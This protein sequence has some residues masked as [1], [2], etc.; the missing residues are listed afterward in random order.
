[1]NQDKVQ[2]E[3][4]TQEL[5]WS[6]NPPTAAHMG[7]AWERM[8]GIVKTCLD[9]VSTIRY[10]SDEMLKSLFAEVMNMVN[11]RPLTY[12][13][14]DSVDDEVLT[15]NHFLVGSSNGSKSPGEFTSSDLLRI[16]W[17]A[18]QMM[19]DKFWHKFVDEYLPTLT[20]RTK[21][22]KKMDNSSEIRGQKG[23]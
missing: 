7:G 21:W 12:A 4:T 9:A 18:V 10:P 8:V 22:F 14:L 15:P 5:K 20:R 13:S 16:D 19:T 3:F 1:M 11:S 23:L 17:R 2:Q 6:F